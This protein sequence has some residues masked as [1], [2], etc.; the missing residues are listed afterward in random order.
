MKIAVIGANGQLGSDL[1][2]ELSLEH[3][4]TSLIHADIEITDIDNVK[5]IGINKTRYTA[6][7]RCL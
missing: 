1:V 6:Q 5:S 4:V 7:H 2:Q 3:K